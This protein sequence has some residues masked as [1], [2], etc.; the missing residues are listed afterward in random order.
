M[1]QKRLYR[2]LTARENLLAFRVAVKETDLFV[3][4][5]KPLEDITRELILKH[6]GIIEA[7]I[8]RY[9]EF[10]DTLQ[11]WRTSGPAPIIINDM[12]SAGEKAGV[13]PMA[14]VAGAIAEHVGIDLLKHTDEVVVENGGDIFLKT[15]G[16]VTIGIFA[17][18]SPIS[19]DMGL[20]VDPGEKPLAV[21]TSSGT[22]GH[23]ISLGKADA[24]CVLSGSCPLAD[25]AATSIGNQI[26]SKAHIGSA[27]DFGKNIKGV[28]G[29]VVI[30]ED[31]IGMWGELEVVRLK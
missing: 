18:K 7:Y 6:R 28:R 16:P 21:C 25:A 20:R 11:P 15:N 29:I 27:I 2:N 13:G 5:D 4:A 24:V 19:L 22:L 30:V 31:K 26:T 3:H 23:S 17:G 10:V 14:A 8:K 12:A 1:Y 9:P